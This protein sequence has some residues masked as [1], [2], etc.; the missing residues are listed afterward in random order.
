MSRS[1]RSNEKVLDHLISELNNIRGSR[2]EWQK[3]CFDGLHDNGNPIYHTNVIMGI[4]PSTVAL[5]THTIPDPSEKRQVTTSL[6]DSGYSLMDL[7]PKQ[8]E[9]FGGNIITLYSPTK[10]QELVVASR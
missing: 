7:T 5:A 10:Q 8:L 1:D 6:L 2:P 4:T 3:V 9:A